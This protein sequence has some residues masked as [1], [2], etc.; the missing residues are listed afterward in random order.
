MEQNEF[1]KFATKHMNM[2]SLSLDKYMSEVTMGG[3][4]ISPSI[5]EERQ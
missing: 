1:R 3:G 5:L 2:N 4:Y